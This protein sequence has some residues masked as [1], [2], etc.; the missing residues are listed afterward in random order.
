MKESLE[1]TF[2]YISTTYLSKVKPFV[3]FKSV[4]IVNA[5][6]YLFLMN[7]IKLH[8]SWLKLF[9][10]LIFRLVLRSKFVKKK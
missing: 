6:H 8:L 2:T 5:E 3:L 4:I 9:T 1:Q 7:S 10:V